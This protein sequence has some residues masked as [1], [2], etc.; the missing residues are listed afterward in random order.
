MPILPVKVETEKKTVYEYG[1]RD[2]KSYTFYKPALKSFVLV[3]QLA[4]SLEDVKETLDNAG[5]TILAGEAG[6]S[7]RCTRQ[8]TLQGIR[9]KAASVRRHYSIA[10]Q[11]L[12]S[13][14]AV[15]RQLAGNK[16]KMKEIETLQNLAQALA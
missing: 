5:C 9:A 2:W 14:R 4:A 1:W 10:L 7:S 13:A 11:P 16:E 12:A 15:A 8:Y 6:R 3:W